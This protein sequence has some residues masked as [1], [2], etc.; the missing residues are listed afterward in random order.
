MASGNTLRELFIKI[1]VIGS[2]RT[3]AVLKRL[4]RMQKSNDLVSRKRMVRMARQVRLINRLIP[5]MGEKMKPVIKQVN[6]LGRAFKNV[7]RQVGR[8]GKLISRSVSRIGRLKNSIFSL[9]NAFV[10]FA[11]FAAA[12]AAGTQKQEPGE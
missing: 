2:E 4:E 8:M 5:G 10:G 1:G 7:G 12:T 11:A 9:K 3:Q 6:R